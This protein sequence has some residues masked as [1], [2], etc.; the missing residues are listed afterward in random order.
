[1]VNVLTALLATGDFK[2][3]QAKQ[4]NYN[5]VVFKNVWGT[6]K[7]TNRYFKGQVL[8]CLNDR[9]AG[10]FEVKVPNFRKPIAICYNDDRIVRFM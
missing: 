10:Y 2:V 5:F 8:S 7:I 6:C 1:M 3:E 9:R 4:N